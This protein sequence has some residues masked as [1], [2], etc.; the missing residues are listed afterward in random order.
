LPVLH[1][2]GTVD[3]LQLSKRHDAMTVQGRL[4]RAVE[5]FER[6]DRREPG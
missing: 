5:A 1:F 6:L 4:E 3:E 2:L